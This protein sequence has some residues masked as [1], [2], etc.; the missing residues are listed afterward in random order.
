[1]S[2]IVFGTPVTT[3]HSMRFF[4]LIVITGVPDVGT[5]IPVTN[6]LTQAQLVGFAAEGPLK[7][8]LKRPPTNDISWN[9]LQSGAEAPQFGVP[10]DIVSTVCTPIANTIGLDVGVSYDFAAPNV[11]TM[12]AMADAVTDPDSRAVIEIRFNH[13]ITY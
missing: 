13:S 2:S 11:L 4:P 6:F 1:M 12:S 3:P 8:M 10:K 9:G 7:E 5:P